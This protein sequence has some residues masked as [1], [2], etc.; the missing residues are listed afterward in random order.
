M[1]GDNTL[2][3]NI[4]SKRD[5]ENTPTLYLFIPAAA[6]STPQRGAVISPP[7]PQPPLAFQ[8]GTLRK[9]R[10]WLVSIILSATALAYAQ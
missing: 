4:H 9:C 7:S 2:V 6:L 1:P 8:V 3:L 10:A 5:F